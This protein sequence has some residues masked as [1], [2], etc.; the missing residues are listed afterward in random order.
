[1]FLMKQPITLSFFLAVPELI[2]S[3][4]FI[5]T[6]IFFLLCFSAAVW[7]FHLIKFVLACVLSLFSASEFTVTPTVIGIVILIFFYMNYLLCFPFEISAWW[8]FVL[9]L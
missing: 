2:I 3:T 5:Y 6:P 8:F 1:M 7:N 9:F 4:F